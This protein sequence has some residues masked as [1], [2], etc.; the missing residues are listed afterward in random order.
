MKL[1]HLMEL[2]EVLQGADEM[3]AEMP[4]EMPE[5]KADMDSVSLESA[6]EKEDEKLE[7]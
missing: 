1:K 4:M 7:V 6:P 3:P 2:I 5:V